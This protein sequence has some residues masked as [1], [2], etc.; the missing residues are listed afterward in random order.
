MCFCVLAVICG[1][2]F[3]IW[4]GGSEPRKRQG[5]AESNRFEN[6]GTIGTYLDV[7]FFSRL[8]VGSVIILLF[9]L[10]WGTGG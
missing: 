5:K 8:Y 6:L 10:M 2:E 4:V 9:L 1:L 7:S 3:G